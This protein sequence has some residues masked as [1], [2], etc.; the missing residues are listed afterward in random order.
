ML[1]VRLLSR[2]RGVSWRR[3]VGF[4]GRAALVSA[5]TGLGVVT[6]AGR[7]RVSWDPQVARCLPDMHVALI[8]L[9]DRTIGH[10]TIVAFRAE[11]EQAPFVPG[12]LI[13][14]IVVGLPGDRVEVTPERTTVN[15]VVVGYGLLLAARAQRPAPSLTRDLVVPRGTVWA[16]G[17][18]ADSYDS[19]YW[20]PLPLWQVVGRVHVLW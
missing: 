11:P 18:T 20:G 8:D 14:K 2:W 15:G 1:T 6:A 17:A 4:A 7:Y 9:A 3:R 13:G 10:G 12:Q 5:L 19:R 16:M